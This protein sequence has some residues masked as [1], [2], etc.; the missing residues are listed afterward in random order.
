MAKTIITQGGDLVNYANIIAVFVDDELDDDENVLS[1]N[2]WGLDV[3]ND[4]IL[5]G[6]YDTLD[7][8]VQAKNKIVEWIDNEAYAK[9]DLSEKAGDAVE[10]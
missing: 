7:E 1:Y 2:L 8:A 3:T 9:V 4:N 6:E 10:Q 5:L